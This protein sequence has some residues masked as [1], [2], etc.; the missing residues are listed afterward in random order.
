MNGLVALVGA[1]EYLPV[2]NEVDRYLLVNCGA[3][4]RAP[5]VVCLPTAAG[6]EG[7]ASWGRWMQMGETHFKALGAEVK[8]LPI[9]DRA[10]ADDTQYVEIIANADFIYF[11]GGNPFYLFE[12]MSGSQAWAAA[13]KA[14]ARGAIYAGCSAGAM[15]MADYIPNWRSLGGQRVRAFGAL[16]KSTVFPHFDKMLIWRGIT[17]PILQSFIPDG[18]Y[19]LGID[20]DTA[21]V[22]KPDGEW[23]VLGRQKVYVITKNEVKTYAAGEKVLLPFQ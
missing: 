3:E 14:W 9:I 20:E 8:S 12:T 1:G 11:S 5:R 10:S 21:L 19:T 18:E 2:M 17:L 16:P 6:Q 22:G 7:E 23:Q 15:I 13:Q 4:A